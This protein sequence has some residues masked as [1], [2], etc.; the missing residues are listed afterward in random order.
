MENQINLVNK[1]AEEVAEEIYIEA[2]NSIPS[3][4]LMLLKWIEGKINMK[5]KISYVNMIGKAGIVYPDPRKNAFL[6]WINARDPEFR[7]RFTICHEFVHI[8]KNFNLKYN[9][10]SNSIFSGKAEERFCDRFAAAFLM[11][12]KIFTEKWITNREDEIYK[13]LR[14]AHFFKVSGEAVY[15]RAKELGLLKEG[16]EK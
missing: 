2:D 11:P 3:S 7:Q 5:I 16:G 6:I 14:L 9:F 8:I 10:S 13:K 15:Y 12:R 4:I 1:K